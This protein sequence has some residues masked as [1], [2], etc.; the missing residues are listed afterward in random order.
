[1]QGK[2]KK[3]KTTNTSLSVKLSSL[4]F[5]MFKT[6]KYARELKSFKINLYVVKYN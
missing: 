4:F 1:M 2:K 3:Q 5:L 6:V